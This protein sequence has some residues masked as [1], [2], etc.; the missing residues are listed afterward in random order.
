MYSNLERYAEYYTAFKLLPGVE[1]NT[2]HEMYAFSGQNKNNAMLQYLLWRVVSGK[3][4]AIT[5]NFMLAGHTKFS[6]DRH[7]GNFKNLYRKTFVS[8][9]PDISEVSPIA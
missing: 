2:M 4:S 9:L 7:F 5:L 3:N 6:P 1:N 8:S